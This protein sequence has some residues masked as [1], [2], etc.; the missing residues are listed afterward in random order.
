MAIVSRMSKGLP[1]ARRGLGREEEGR[2]G[3]RG[4]WRG[5]RREEGGGRGR[6]G[7]GGEERRGGAR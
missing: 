7:G 4:G 6:S 5:M 3:A 2:E 1:R